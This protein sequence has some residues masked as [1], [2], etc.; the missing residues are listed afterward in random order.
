MLSKWKVREVEV[1]GMTFYQV[2][3]H[4]DAVKEKNQIETSGGYWSTPKEAK[5]LADKL[6]REEGLI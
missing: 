4:T 3:R 1:A 5:T 2:C 6:N